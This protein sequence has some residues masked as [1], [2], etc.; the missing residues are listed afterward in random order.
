MG[1]KKKKNGNQKTL[2]LLTLVTAILALIESILD[3][4]ERL[5]R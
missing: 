4:V 2:A 1:K 3:L 5:T